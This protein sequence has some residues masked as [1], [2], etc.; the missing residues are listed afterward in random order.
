VHA[1][2]GKQDLGPEVPTP[3][4]A[5]LP[6][7]TGT[8][9]VNADEPWRNQQ[10]KAAEM[11]APQL[12]VPKSFQL[13]SGLTVLVNERPGIPIVSTNLV[14]KTGSGSNPADKPG[15][16][17]FTA[18]MLDEG[19]M[20]RS[21]LQI[22]DEVAQLGGSL[23]T[24]STM[25]AIQVSGRSLVRTFPQLL[26]LLAD[27]VRHP[28]FP[29]DEI[30]RQRAS[31]L[32]SLVQQREDPSQ[33]ASVTMAAALFGP[34]H[35]YGFSEIGTESSNKAMMR[36]DLQKFWSQNFVA[37]NAA[38]IVSGN[39]TVDDLKPL[40]EK[41][42]GDWQKGMPVTDVSGQTATT[43]ARLVLVDKPGA[44]QTQLRVASIGV[45]RNT[46]D[47]AGLRV[48]N[49]AL[50][51]LFSSRINLNLRE[52]HGYTY[53]AGSQFV[54]RRGAGPFL[55]AT[56]V[57]TNVTAPAVTEIFKELKRI[58]ES[59]LTP[60]ELSLARDS[61][62]RSLPS[63]FETSP[64]ATATT[65][66]IFIYDLG[67]DYYAKLP[68]RLSAITAADVRAL[69]EKYIAP[70]KMI[71]VAV[72]DRTKIGTELQKLNLGAVEMR[73][74]DGSL[75]GAAVRASSNVK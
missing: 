26:D 28:G 51:G 12:P 8:E 72:G 39:I 46:P 18:A 65:A 30:E 52:E 5:K 59:D 27:V 15:L 7:G 47:Y 57:R 2:S 61:I 6:A 36:E 9:T 11:R 44:P 24:G 21:A 31:R 53:G 40:V 68:D 32:A 49:E 3:D 71:V 55:V 73:N 19:T 42:F 23:S 38:L 33:A 16:A 45:A 13:P 37:N 25:D 60:A 56:G 67:L 48:L 43:A 69:A 50:G 14:L 17:N 63:D 1:V 62:I 64:S 41:A 58:R 54:F 75:S 35:P 66:T 74:A 10:P 29:G 34:S 22:A 20:S 4:V 70:E